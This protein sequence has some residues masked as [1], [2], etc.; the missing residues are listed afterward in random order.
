MAIKGKS[1]SRG[2]RRV[3]AAPPRPTLVVRKP[4]IWKRRWVWATLGTVGA[5]AILEVTFVGEAEPVLR[6]APASDPH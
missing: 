2:G 4:P 5:A 1:K 6:G 3:V